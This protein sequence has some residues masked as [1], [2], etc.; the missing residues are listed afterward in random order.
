MN[1]YI[2]CK[3]KRN[4]VLTV[5]GPFHIALS[6]YMYNVYNKVDPLSM[7]VNL[8]CLSVPLQT[9]RVHLLDT[10]SFETTF[11]KKAQRKKP[12]LKVADYQVMIY[13]LS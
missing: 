12:S 7:Y 4:V 9:A 2:S 3:K 8:I 11:G 6:D 1:R 5:N 10:E 13:L